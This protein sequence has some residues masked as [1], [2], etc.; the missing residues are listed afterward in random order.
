MQRG[1][2]TGD[3]KRSDAA[4]QIGNALFQDGCGWVRDPAVTVTFSFKVEQSGAVIGA[5]ERVG[6]RLVDRNGDRLGRRIGVVAG[7]N[8]NGLVAHCSPLRSHFVM[9]FF[10]S[11]LVRTQA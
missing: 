1:L 4:F 3:R 8:C 7:V 10:A 11:V 5:V 9:R 2:S 6:D